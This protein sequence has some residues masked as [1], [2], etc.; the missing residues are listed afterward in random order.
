MNPEPIDVGRVG[1]G[2]GGAMDLRGK[3]NPRCR[4]LPR[5]SERF[6]TV[7][8]GAIGT[9]ESHLPHLNSGETDSVEKLIVSVRAGDLP[10]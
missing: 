7:G 10:R 9:G 3:Q 1:V 6:F 5:I 4:N 8:P 2:E